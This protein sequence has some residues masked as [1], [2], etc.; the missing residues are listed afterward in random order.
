[1]REKNKAAQELV[2]LR[3][4]KGVTKAH[5]AA[6]REN[7]KLGGRP[8]AKRCRCG[9]MTKARAKAEKHRCELY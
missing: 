4:L 8:K 3:F 6:A 1:M 7:G 5:Q 9:A 2:A